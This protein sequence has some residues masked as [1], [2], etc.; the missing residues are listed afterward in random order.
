MVVFGAKF[1]YLRNFSKFSKACKE[2][3]TKFKKKHD[4]DMDGAKGLEAQ[5]LYHLPATSG[6][7]RFHVQWY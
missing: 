7:R 2:N 3:V 6:F 4:F 5:I 1:V